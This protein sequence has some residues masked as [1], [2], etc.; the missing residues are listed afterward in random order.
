MGRGVW[1]VL[2][3]DVDIPA[4][5]L[6]FCGRCD[7]GN[8]GSGAF[9]GLRK[10]KIEDVGVFLGVVLGLEVPASKELT[11]D[12]DD[13][14]WRLITAFSDASLYVVFVRDSTCG[15][16]GSSNVAMD[17]RPRASL[18]DFLASLEALIRGWS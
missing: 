15:D 8:S 7:N 12:R 2:R 5:G 4:A 6:L 11:S 1:P 13:S 16:C 10:R 17:G 9:L 3:E 14:D 18:N